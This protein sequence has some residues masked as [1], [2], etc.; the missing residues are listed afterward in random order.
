M[1]EFVC[2]FMIYGICNQVDQRDMCAKLI[3]MNLYSSGAG[4]VSVEAK[5]Q[6]QTDVILVSSSFFSFFEL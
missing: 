5:Q 2:I 6:T 1:H 4:I 3:N